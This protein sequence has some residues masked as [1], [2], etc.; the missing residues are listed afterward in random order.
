ML[1]EMRILHLDLKEARKRECLL[2]WVELEHKET[3]KL[4]TE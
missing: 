2:H 1:E 4:F 3:S